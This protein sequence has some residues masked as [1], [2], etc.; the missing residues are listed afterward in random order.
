AKTLMLLKRY[1]E[2]LRNRLRAGIIRV[3]YHSKPRFLI[4]GAQKAGTTALYYYLS[5]HP[6]TIPSKEK[7]IELF[8]PELYQDWPEHPQHRILC[9]QNGTDFFDPRTYP[10]TA[11][12]YHSHFPLPHELGR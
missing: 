12:W 4:I 7:E 5:E 8:T 10:K 1:R 2:A 3:G 9:A 11:A 6:N